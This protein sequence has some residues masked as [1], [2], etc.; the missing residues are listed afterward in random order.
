MFL[1]VEN[2]TAGNSCFPTREATTTSQAQ[3]AAGNP[4]CNIRRLP[5]V[6]W[7]FKVSDSICV[8]KSE[9]VNLTNEMNL[10][11]MDTFIINYRHH[12]D[13]TVCWEFKGNNMKVA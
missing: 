1:F 9:C 6:C 3:S 11:I 8:L 5:K 2:F 7:E 4:S 12:M 10:Q 13:P